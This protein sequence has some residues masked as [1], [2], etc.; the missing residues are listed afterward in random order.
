MAH[1]CSAVEDAVGM[2][3]IEPCQAAAGIAIAA[4]AR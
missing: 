3:I 2:P 1:H 4:L